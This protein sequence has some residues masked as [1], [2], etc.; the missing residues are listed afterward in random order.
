MWA[1]HPPFTGSTLS[2]YVFPNPSVVTRKP[3]VLSAFQEEHIKI[4]QAKQTA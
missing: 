3:R 1:H 2:L 4:K